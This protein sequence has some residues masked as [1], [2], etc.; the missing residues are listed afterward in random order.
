P[1]LSFIL[2]SYGCGH[3]S[4]PL[5]I[6][7]TTPTQDSTAISSSTPSE[8]ILDCNQNS[9]LKTYTKAVFKFS[10][11]MARDQCK[12]SAV[13]FSQF[14]LESGASCADARFKA[15][16]ATAWARCLSS[17][18]TDKAVS[19]GFGHRQLC[20]DLEGKTIREVISE[21]LNA[22]EAS[23]TKAGALKS[24]I[25][26]D[27]D[28]HEALEVD[29]AVSVV[30]GEKGKVV[31]TILHESA[32]DPMLVHWVP[33]RLKKAMQ[34]IAPCSGEEELLSL[35][36]VSEAE[37]KALEKLGQSGSDDHAAVRNHLVHQLFEMQ[38]LKTPQ[39]TAI[40][41]QNE[42][43]VTYSALNGMANRLARYILTVVPE[44][45]GIIALCLEK[46]VAM[47][48][49]ILAVLK[50]GKA[51]VPLDRKNPRNRLE[52]ILQ[53]TQAALTIVSRSTAPILYGTRAIVL[54]EVEKDLQTLSSAN[55]DLS[56]K[57]TDLCHVL[58]T[59]GSTGTPKGVMIE[60]AAMVNT[61]N[62][63]ADYC[64]ITT[65]T[66]TLQFATY[67]FDVCGD[68]I[69]MTLA[70]GGCLFL[71]PHSQLLADLNG[72]VDR[73]RIN[74]AQLTPTV[75]NLLVPN[76]IPSL[77]T[78]VSSGEAMTKHMVSTWLG[79]A[80][81]INAYGPTET[82]VCTIS[83]VTHR[84][85]ENCIGKPD[86]G[87][88]VVILD[89]EGRRTPIG[90]VGELCVAG[91]QLFRGY[92]GDPDMT[93]K[94]TF[95]HPTLG[96]LYKT[97]DLASFGNDGEIY[98]HGRQDSQI[99]VLGNRIDLTEIETC[100]AAGEWARNVVVTVP[101][102]GP[103][104]GRLAAILSLTQFPSA[105]EGE[106]LRCLSAEHAVEVATVLEDV[107]N[108][109]R[110]ELPSH[111]IPNVWFTVENI[112]LTASGKVDRTAAREWLETLDEEE[113]SKNVQ[114]P[115][116]VNLVGETLTPQEET[117]RGIWSRLLSL[118]P[119]LI[120]AD[121]SFFDLGGDSISVIRMV[122]AAR[123]TGFTISVQ[124][125][126]TLK[127]LRL[128][129]F[130]AP[131]KAATNGAA[132]PLT[133]F[134]ILPSKTSPE[135]LK[136]L[137]AQQCNLDS[138]LGSVIDVYPCTPL[139]EG[140]MALSAKSGAYVSD[141]VFRL[142]EIDPIRFKTAWGSVLQ[143][144]EILRTR[145]VDIAPYGSLQVVVD[146]HMEWEA[147]G[148]SLPG[149][150]NGTRQPMVYGDQ[151]CRFA[152]IFEDSH[153]YFVLTMHH[154]IYDGW[155]LSILK[156]KLQAA[157]QSGT[158]SPRSYSYN[159]FI[160]YLSDQ[161]PANVIDFWTS[162]LEGASVTDYPELPGQCEVRA[163][164]TK[165]VAMNIDFQSVAKA[166]KIQASTVVR[167]TWAIVLAQHS[168]SDDVTF[169]VTLSGRNVPLEGIEEMTGPTLVTVPF[170]VGICDTC[171]LSDLLLD[172]QT[173]AVE[174]MPFEHTGIQNI[175]K[176][177]AFAKNA[178]A[179]RTL[180]VVQP[181]E[182][183]EPEFLQHAND[184]DNMQRSYPITVECQLKRAGMEVHVHFD[185]NIVSES[186]VDWILVHLRETLQRLASCSGTETVR[187][188]KVSG[189]EDVQQI[190]QWNRQCPPK[191][192]HCLHRLFEK[193]VAENPLGIA[194]YDQAS[195]SHMSY[196]Q[197]DSMATRLA[198]RL[199]ELG[200]GPEKLVPICFEKSAMAIVAII[201][202]LKAGG[203]YVPL[204][205]SHPQQRLQYIIDAVDAK[206]L[207]CSPSCTARFDGNVDQVIPVDE[208][209]ILSHQ[210]P[211]N[212]PLTCQVQSDNAAFVTY[213]SG[214]TGVPKAVVLTHSAISTSATHL[215]RF[216]GIR[217]D[218]KVLQFTS[219][220]F[221]MS[222]KEIFITLL[223]GG[224]ICMPTEH[225]RLNAL[226]KAAGEMCVDVAFLTPTVARLLRPKDCPTLKILCLGGEALTRDVVKVWANKARV[227]NSYGPTET[228]MNVSA[229]SSSLEEDADLANIGRAVTGCI[230]I[231][232]LDEPR[233]LAPIG[234]PGEIA[235]SGHTLARGY[236]NDVKKTKTA[237]IEDPSWAEDSVP[238]RCYLTGD[239]GRY[240]SDGTIQYIGRLDRQVKFNGLRIELGEIE[241]HIEAQNQRISQ[242]VAQLVRIG[243]QS[244][245]TLAVFIKCEDLGST[246]EPM[247]L[248]LP[249]SNEFRK[250]TADARSRLQDVLPPYMVPKFFVPVSEV[251]MT[252]SGKID[253]RALIQ[254]AS[255]LSLQELE[256][257]SHHTGKV[258]R[259]LLPQ[260][261][262][263]RSLCDLWR[264]V[265]NVPEEFPLT[266]SDHFFHL[267]GDSIGAIRLVTAARE[268]GFSLFVS[269]IHQAP[270]LGEMASCM[271]W[272]AKVQYAKIAPFSLAEG[273]ELEEIAHLCQLP[274][275][276]I[277]DVYP[278]TAFQEGLMALSAHDGA[279]VA[280]RVYN[281][282]SLDASQFRTAWEKLV[283][284]NPILRTR[285]VYSAENIS[286][287]VV[288]NDSVSEL[289]Q[290][291]EASNLEEYLRK[292]RKDP[293]RPGSRL[294][295][296]ALIQEKTASYFVLTLHHA[297]YDGWSME[298]LLDDLQLAYA[299]IELPERPAFNCVVDFLCK[300]DDQSNA[301]YWSHLLEG[302]V[303]SEFPPKTN[304]MA[305]AQ[306]TCV[307]E[308]E[309]VVEHQDLHGR[310]ASF[311]TV[312]RA[313]WALVISKY[314][315]CRD[316]VFGMTLSGRE[317]DVAGIAE[318]VGPTAVTVPVRIEIDVHETVGEFLQR[319]Q[320][321]AVSMLPFQHAGLQKIQR[322]SADAKN[323]CNFRNILVVQNKSTTSRRSIVPVK[324]KTS[325]L[326]SY[327]TVEC[328]PTDSGV[329][330]IA[331][332]DSSHIN[333]TQVQRLLRQ[334]ANVIR[335]M[336]SRSS[337]PK[338]MDS[339][340]MV[341]VEDFE[342]IQSWNVNCSPRVANCVHHL[343]EAEAAL[344]PDALAI[345]TT[346][347]KLTYREL[348]D[349]ATRLARH[350]ISIGIKSGDLI[351][352]CMR[353]SGAMVVAMLAIM[354]VGAGYVPID[355][356]SG[357][358][359][360]EHLLNQT[361]AR[362]AIVD[363]TGERIFDSLVATLRVDTAVL[364]ELPI[365]SAVLPTIP[366]SNVAYIIFTSG[367]TGKP[368]G[369]VLEHS[370]LCTS[371]LEQG[372][373]FNLRRNTRVLQ[374][375]SYTFDVSVV[376]IF[377]TLIH[378]GC[379]CMPSEE[380][381]LVELGKAIKL[382]SVETAFLTPTVADLL[383]PEDTPL[384]TLI[385][386]GE[387]HSRAHIE[388][389]ADRL[390]LINGYGPTEAS[391]FSCSGPITF[392][393]VP[394]TIGRAVGGLTWVTEVDS[395]QLAAIGTVG[396]LV[397]SGNNLARGYLNDAVRTDA[398]FIKDLPS[399]PGEDRT[400]SPKY[401]YKT[402]DLVRY[403]PDGTLQYLGRRD[404]QVKIHGQRIECGEVEYAITS[405]GNASQAFVELIK[406][407]GTATLVGFVRFAP[408]VENSS[409]SESG[410]RV[411][412]SESVMAVIQDLKSAL[413]D[414]LPLYM[415]PSVFVP[416]TK[417][418]TTVSGKVDRG[419]LKAITA[420]EL[421][422]YI[423]FED[424]PKRRPRT[425]NEKAMQELWAKT[426]KLNA[427][428][429]GLDDNFFRLGGDSISTILLVTGARKI[430]FALDIAKIYQNPRLEKMASLL[431]LAKA[432]EEVKPFSL[433]HG[434][435]PE[436]CIQMA[437]AQCGVDREAIGDVYPC[438]PL[439]E[440]LMA[441]S[442]K[443]PGA[444]VTQR[445]YRLPTNI[446]LG[447]LQKAWDLT[448]ASNA[449][450]RT[451]IILT[452]AQGSM[453]VVVNA[454][455]EWTLEVLDIPTY[456]SLDRPA[457]GY[458]AALC[459]QAFVFDG[460][461]KSLVFTLHHCIYDGFSWELIIDDLKEAYENGTSINR[462]PF[463]SFIKH[464]EKIRTDTAAREFWGTNLS[465]AVAVD[466]PS[467]V[468]ADRQE[469][470]AASKTLRLDTEAEFRISSE[471]IT[472]ASL[473][474]AAWAL[475]I[476]R[477]S[478]SEDV[479]FG[480][481]MSGRTAP[482]GG[483]E[484]VSGPT[485][486]TVPTRIRINNAMTVEEY[487]R[488][489]H[490]ASLQRMPFE[491]FGL[492]NIRRLSH[493][494]QEACS[495]QSLLVIQ[496]VA[497]ESTEDKRLQLK[498]DFDKSRMTE[499][500]CLSVECQK[501][502][503]GV[504]LSAVYDDKAV[505]SENVR[506]ILYHFSQAIQQLAKGHVAI[507]VRISDIS[508]FGQQDLTQIKL[509]NDVHHNRIDRCVHHAFCDRAL[510]HP[511]RV[512]IHA[513]DGIRTYGEVD[514]LSSVLSSKLIDAGVGPDVLVPLYF[515][516]SSLMIIAMLA[517]LKAGGGYVPLD[518]SQPQKRLQYIVREVG[519]RV[520]LCSPG[521]E[522]ACHAL[523]APSVLPVDTIHLSEK[524]HFTAHNASVT[525]RNIA[526]VMFTSGSTG[527]PKGVV[528]EHS[529]VTTSLLAHGPRFGFTDSLRVLQFAGYTFDTSV[530]EIFS[531]L[532]HGGCV[533]I[534]SEEERLV[535]LPRIINEM[536]IQM[537]IL[538]PTTVSN[539]LSPELVPKLETLI[540]IGEPMTRRNVLTWSQ[541]VR[542]M[543]DY[544]PTETCM[545]SAS[546]EATGPDFNPASIGKGVAAH[547]WIADPERTER[548]TPIGCIGELIISG[549]TLARGYLNDP[550]KTSAAFIDGASLPW[551]KDALGSWTK[552]Y[553]TGDLVHYNTDGTLSCVGRKDT[554]VKLRGQRIEVSEIEHHLCQHPGV[555]NAAVES[556]ASMP[557]FAEARLIA[558][559]SLDDAHGDGL[560]TLTES[561]D[562]TLSKAVTKLADVLPAYMVPSIFLPLGK[563]PLTGSGKTDRKELRRI[564]S[565]LSTEQLAR[566]RSGSAF[567]QRPETAVEKKLHA[568]WTS[569]L[570]LPPASIGLDDNFF[571]L[572]GDS[573][574][575]IRLVNAGR[576]DG[577]AF[578]V[579]SVFQHPRLGLMAKALQKDLDGSHH[580]VT[581]VQAI[582]D[583]TLQLAAS[584]CGMA[585]ADIEDVYAC[586]PLQEGLMALSVGHPGAYVAQRVYELA[587]SMDLNRFCSAWEKTVDAHPILRTRIIQ[588]GD[589]E[590]GSI[591]VVCRTSAKL[592]VIRKYL[593]NDKQEPFEYGRPLM[594]CA[595]ISSGGKDLVY[596]VL[597]LH[598]SLYDGFSFGLILDDFYSAYAN[599]SAPLPART[600]FKN[601][602]K[603]TQAVDQEASQTFWKSYLAGASLSDFLSLPASSHSLRATAWKD[604]TVDIPI[605]QSTVTFP[606]II[607]AA[608][609][610]TIS[611]H[612]LLPSFDAH[613]VI[614]GATLSGRTAPVDG[615]DTVAGPTILTLPVRVTVSY[616][617]PISEFLEAVHS[618]AAAMMPF[619]HYG[620]QKI[621][622][623]S[624]DA[625]RACQFK[626][627]LVIHPPTASAAATMR[628][629]QLGEYTQMMQTYGIVMECQITE[630]GVSLSAQFDPAAIDSQRMLWV[631]QHF[632]KAIEALSRNASSQTPVR[633]AIHQMSTREEFEQIL[634][635]NP[636][637][638]SMEDQC[639]TQLIEKTVS[640]H[641]D[642]PAVTGPD[643]TLT[644]AELDYQT[645]K[646]ARHLMKRGVGPEVF[647]PICF[648]KS[649]LMIVAMLG[650]LKA[651]GAYVPLDPA[652]PKSRLEY[653][654]G[655]T[656]AIIVLSSSSQSHIFEDFIDVETVVIDSAFFAQNQMTNGFHSTGTP[657]ASPS[658]AAYVIYTSG[659]T[660][661]PKGVV[662][663]HGS[664]CKSV[665]EHGT[666]FGHSMIDGV[667]VLQFCS[668]TFD[669]SV[670]DIFT[671]LTYGG[672]LCIP[673][674][675]DRLYNL[676]HT[677][678]KMQVD[679]VILT[680]TV[681][682]LLNPTEVPNLKVLAM[683]GEALSP[684][685]VKTWTDG[686]MRV[687]NGY[688]PTEASVDCAAAVV[689]SNTLPNNIGYS[690][691]GLVWITEIE[692]HNTLAPLGCVGE[693]VIS[694]GI[695]AR[696]YLN[697]PTRTANAFIDSVSW[698]PQAYGSPRI[699]KTGDLARYASDGSIEYL[700]RKDTQVK[701]H[702]MRIEMGEIESSLGNC[703]AVVQS[704]VELCSRNRVDMLVGFVQLQGTTAEERLIPLTQQISE[705]LDRIE[706]TIK[707]TL[708]PYMVPGILLPVSSIPRTTSGKT[709]RRALKD[710]FSQLSEAPLSTYRRRHDGTAKQLPSTT[711][712]KLVCEI[713]AQILHLEASEIGLHD[714]FFVLGGDSISAIQLVSA[715][716]KKGLN[717]AVSD[718]HRS[719]DLG[720]MAASLNLDS[721]SPPS[722]TIEIPEFSLVN[723]QSVSDLVGVVSS[724]CHVAP[725]AVQDIYP[726][727]P[728][729]EGM[730]ALSTRET[731]AYLSQKVYRLSPSTDLGRLRNAWESVLVNNDI[732]RT[733][734]VNVTTHGSLQVVLKALDPWN[735][736]N[737][738]DQHLE[739]E[740]S[741]TLAYGD[742]LCRY[743]IFTNDS[744]ESFF[745]LS[746]HHALYDGWS[747]PLI[748]EDFRL[749]YDTRNAL[750]S[751]PAYKN[752]VK[753][754]SEAS[755]V[756]S[757]ASDFW[758]NRLSGVAPTEFP[759]KRPS[760]KS[761]VTAVSHTRL[762]LGKQSLP[763]KVTTASLV[764]AAWGVVLARYT[765]T[766]D[767]CFGMALTGRNAPVAGIESITGP[768]Q[769][770]VPVRI[771][772][773]PTASPASL[774]RDVHS[775]SVEMIPY[776]HVGLQNI[777]GF[778]ES[779]KVCEFSNFLIIQPGR[780]PAK[781]GGD[782]LQL[783]QLESPPLIQQYALA[784]ECEL[785]YDASID[786]N[787]FFDPI[788]IDSS[789]IEW[790]LQHF[791]NVIQQLHALCMDESACMDKI[792]MSTQF[793]EEMVW[794][795]NKN[796]P[797]ASSTCIHNMIEEQAIQ[798]PDLSAIVSHDGNL[799]YGE[800]EKLSSQVGHGILAMGIPPGTII[801][802][803]I[804]RSSTMVIS[805]LGIMKAGSSYIPIDPSFPDSRIQYILGE[806]GA[807]LALVSE[808]TANRF[809]GFPGMT[810]VSVEKI[811]SQKFAEISHLAF[812]TVSPSDIAYILFTSGSTGNPKGVVMEHSALSTTVISESRDFGIYQGTRMLQSSNLT[813]DTSIAQIFT[814]LAY[815]GCLC[816]SSEQDFLDHPVEMMNELQV[817]MVILTP[818]VLALLD[819]KQIPSLKTVI[820]GGE[821]MT[822]ANIK[823]AMDA[824]V[825][826]IN[827]YGPTETCIDV[828]VNGNVTLETSP[829]NL[830]HVTSACAWILDLEND[831]RLAPLG[832]VGELAFS[833]P[834]LAR[835]Y[836][837]QPE[838]TKA[839]FIEN[840][841]WMR[842]K[843]SRV[844]KTGDLARFNGDGSI[845]YLGRRDT[846][847]KVNGQRIEL[848]EVENKMNQLRSGMQTA[849]EVFAASNRSILVAF[850]VSGASSTGSLINPHSDEFSR[851]SQGIVA[852]L[853]EL[854]P[855][856]M[857]PSLY[858][859]ISHLPLN[860]SAKLDRKKLRQA[861][862]NLSED[863]IRGYRFRATGE[864]SV[865][866]TEIEKTVQSLWAK[867]LGIGDPLAIEL[868]DG[869]F[870]L[871]GDSITAIQLV[872]A[873]RRNGYRLTVSDVFAAPKL[874]KM[875]ELITK[876][877]N[878]VQ[879]QS[880]SIS[881]AVP[882]PFSLINFPDLCLS[883]ISSDM[884]IDET[885][886]EDVYPATPIQQACVIEGQKWHKAYYA[887]FP[888]DIEGVLDTERLH[889]ACQ[890]VVDQH[891]VLRTIFT[892]DR[893]G[894]LQ[895]VLR[896]LSVDFQAAQGDQDL[897]SI[898][899]MCQDDA[900][901][902]FEKPMAK[903]RLLS[904]GNTHRLV[905]GLSHSQYDGMCLN[906]ILGD[907]RTAYLYQTLP[908]RPSYSL[909][910]DYSLKANTEAAQSFWR[911]HLK[912]SNMTHLVSRPWP[913]D[914]HFL[915][916][917][918]ERRIPNPPST[919]GV[920]FS[921]ILNAAWSLVL[922]HLL[923]QPDIVFGTLVSGRS[924][925]IDGIESMIGPCMNILPLRVSLDQ[926]R[927]NKD[928]LQYVRAQQSAMIPYETTS[929]SDI[930]ENCTS[931][932]ISTRFGSVVQHQ[933]IPAATQNGAD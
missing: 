685:L 599:I 23:E 604:L 172:V 464:V 723:T 217:Q 452:E 705:V 900:P 474:R 552:I 56:T 97:G 891:P 390:Q 442:L 807:G 289:W 82:N 719:N 515:K 520:I 805:L 800:L 271:K 320:Q 548:L 773:D 140:L 317:A 67:T 397:I 489:V 195:A 787:A 322:L 180:L 233:R 65:E 398:V 47:I 625:E 557:Q 763:N 229:T 739:E 149:Y 197:L 878:P 876:D 269:Q 704:A 346:S 482:I 75:I 588:A 277:E 572:G 100:I 261:K 273:V 857:I 659:S 106:R 401:M 812:P 244:D 729:Q 571:R 443:S 467:R 748:M 782:T 650:I 29:L 786:L 488:D 170:R 601:Y 113:Y 581:A 753:F 200:V 2:L 386:M 391:I 90:A 666:K 42:E 840:P 237:F 438:S 365:A 792:V 380:E 114:A 913:N 367:S 185:D 169:G 881:P 628:M 799:N 285:I 360:L 341:T 544:G 814:T 182:D 423:N 841:L 445:V 550:A 626:N 710:L 909:F 6:I 911:T 454:R 526:Y 638:P 675:S 112:P 513:S 737:N 802:I 623:L 66:R 904:R 471:S 453:Q 139:Q 755:S 427:D 559:V 178:C 622:R 830:G 734:I 132:S 637:Y 751:H 385:L 319:I 682:K 458:G 55:L 311:A 897:D 428:R 806:V 133:P 87:S 645:S 796:C 173:R 243:Q 591:Q 375:C 280:Q 352:I 354:K 439:Q 531:T 207:L 885:L 95:T 227:I 664:I 369:V 505:E 795:W 480:E 81:L 473:L 460:N 181:E 1:V 699:Y 376:E 307:E 268:I 740:R 241:H 883:Q 594:R 395:N 368:K 450:L 344:H 523:G 399:M 259:E 690:L 586:S 378:G 655:Q 644:Y 444:Y 362:I 691:G 188:L 37:E 316:V 315:D 733:R 624:P 225:N 22:G 932:P 21:I 725:E 350:L 212:Q 387:P 288:C 417:F 727:S 282:S 321:Q 247:P 338:T 329:S 332:Y 643:I 884:A 124:D 335:Q 446:D 85:A 253:R 110:L 392:Q 920:T 861:Y 449:I 371:L 831:D 305:L 596:F 348:E 255:Q 128:L 245:P 808:S 137:V 507:P 51:W 635:W 508:L 827:D 880:Q 136:R 658:D 32:V 461:S 8:K 310:T 707:K 254:A 16:I 818:T 843:P 865:P 15:T 309:T 38:V 142:P 481:T 603:Y 299:G 5:D 270:R 578:T 912:D 873:F 469:V 340:A 252:T 593:E 845:Q 186:D 318:I 567:K 131:D 62:W 101:R 820:L 294:C 426:L 84:P 118:P 619:E 859:P 853:K 566:Y 598:H 678:N 281:L 577:L 52:K 135:D 284:L 487:L 466:F 502:L 324:E 592:E 757:E 634:T 862:S 159:I 761:K 174:M 860:L 910:I 86:Y 160:K 791:S 711:A 205:V 738:L 749:A 512:A 869:F 706:R 905:V 105:L 424:G 266:T 472:V 410:G 613:D 323:A 925:P 546:S 246:Q 209:S 779:T 295:R 448:V 418:P 59:S 669:V 653:I 902:S 413:E 606:T 421:S 679:L 129:S 119:R 76:K 213:T 127:T 96:R 63:L 803:C 191:V 278:C 892:M 496:P 540:L 590:A 150:L 457:M 283:K 36:I 331:H 416:Y 928:L 785:N 500:Y 908:E 415:I 353:K 93:Q 429:I 152:L 804:K 647:V 771:T 676:A 356:S 846:Q 312:V 821:P 689:T 872:A 146:A 57:P 543:N 717:L 74:Y 672:C 570:Q 221:D 646:L 661:Q 234:C 24:A 179:F 175:Q 896:Q 61:V 171:H 263:E 153:W 303:P 130:T 851:L 798:N 538:T 4:L 388:K 692:D 879:E 26:F 41:S 575:A 77:K 503:T 663:E 99:K 833:G 823:A 117:M 921:T 709:D 844:Y 511:K 249:Y 864:K 337:E 772:I 298:L 537:A 366:P 866:T 393:S 839:A 148:N 747:L 414:T 384:Q 627:L 919:H 670:V 156:E 776:E 498:L 301:K 465:G 157:Y 781:T 333:S 134:S 708:P 14:S 518:T 722:N 70:R 629:T 402:G 89:P 651:G 931:W 17:L 895:V 54:E 327:F 848:G 88:L 602:V 44:D 918:V 555:R 813:F 381:R 686:T 688:G 279:Y 809:D 728:L 695:L 716:R 46:S 794:S 562:T 64:T 431:V 612:V 495:F 662:I 403:N 370:T 611:R 767:V 649:S 264:K 732:L 374:F 382:M 492:Q 49:S 437:A 790:L 510:L 50:A 674:E 18:S 564:L 204:D 556:T 404:T 103:A 545:D 389:W 657:S 300:A 642:R 684:E 696:G 345:V 616:D 703:E 304:T 154:A 462:T 882:P 797:E 832:C 20:L 698:M 199:Q 226:S 306:T 726:C 219:F 683:T 764:R 667:R 330:I 109:L 811:L 758:R 125:V 420:E 468:S 168:N 408:S 267:G 608:W 838:K 258:N 167:T 871:G 639:L 539:L 665:I 104:K 868:D 203:A 291:S 560:L 440:G 363:P 484:T 702:G 494:A 788:V 433:V 917:R 107:S 122:S 641:P 852:R 72:F 789:R 693:L 30:L 849:V 875:C 610:V 434:I 377:G 930:V 400:G 801:P 915:Q 600:P 239:A 888:I 768:T 477:Y 220:T 916:S 257:S 166:Q 326:Q 456:L 336:I 231:V 828:V 189:D 633:H 251:P 286:L 914:R 534:P 632:S 491:H 490:T 533:C 396:E 425:S 677:I 287:Q 901:V 517:V 342:E 718:I 745:V 524:P 929:F 825:R 115:G 328:N 783:D 45:N 183:Q 730:V 411:L 597:T 31:V 614:F 712:E 151:L 933:N 528:L 829:N 34:Q 290:T 235:I 143:N 238:S 313:A 587:R 475:V 605:V 232:T 441:L 744:G 485:I 7:L 656:G 886:I 784:M 923:G 58:F 39:N 890:S 176:M 573:M 493:D 894:M 554:Q 541:K 854:L 774:L 576:K 394:N 349:Y 640:L 486:V 11:S 358:G 334:F 648:E 48:V 25:Y 810:V 92:L 308:L 215:G 419:Q 589:Y 877:E 83:D 27:L 870:E 265:L 357:R 276:T 735:S 714:N 713:W 630:T 756:S 504:S 138:Q 141:M 194:I 668:Y 216:Y 293:I 162:R 660:G 470:F 777:Q 697:D 514:A 13:Q 529:A 569:V 527:Q 406:H 731:G 198:H 479:I 359:R 40:E 35:Y 501:T 595:L 43:P 721:S 223:N 506:W 161:K 355:G 409:S 824:G 687:M 858:I 715:F 741:Q 3:L 405:L 272:V 372:K 91:P 361:K 553:K 700:G 834:S 652:H 874:R 609:A 116:G 509:W 422:V 123:K 436:E 208:V 762:A 694:G 822:E 274:P 192:D 837:N 815:G 430:G 80:R 228:C 574:S 455:V 903:F 12:Q 206:V 145:I 463:T 522:D 617:Q 79:H 163:M 547:L 607:R 887:W 71:A 615:L 292:D 769:T 780:S 579:A 155:S 760:H 69:F 898:L 563:I 451:R 187:E 339:I 535:S 343:F 260:S 568:I 121:S 530:M 190:H 906:L 256:I 867:T 701:L 907:I 754:V 585:P 542:L 765:N 60:H 10:A 680:P 177:S 19:F 536:G 275:G 793:D 636:G 926:T 120:S 68:D 927:T 836:L 775:Q 435:T 9:S 364:E 302:A 835:G 432:E 193:K 224:C 147:A 236:R 108:R 580:S 158:P 770:A 412:P 165:T 111:M 759:E 499:T 766:N 53:S 582:D 28:N 826:L 478:N 736:G 819:L 164:N 296:F 724:Q 673:S 743:G 196:P 842:S 816:I 519:T 33:D 314:L 855:A 373:A 778:V 847:V 565:E 742:A 497:R 476:A 558:L 222:L 654:L 297:L 240:N 483:I 922:A 230:W 532:L 720:D 351:P 525:S 561:I 407:D 671:T 681:A 78:L 248:I 856:Y 750:P 250:I 850:V 752:F 893:R 184:L 584:S 516:K 746:V 618:Q 521:F 218:M 620:L 214:S 102:S 144:E 447:R 379:V 583:A 924:A 325:M 73:N 126:F 202:V 98:C 383:Q 863:E 94:K 551:G 631:L 889:R 201:A 242:A 347:S 211:S 262:A 817:E 621:R 459:R 899:E 549:P 210:S